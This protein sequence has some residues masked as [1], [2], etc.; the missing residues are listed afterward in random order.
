VLFR[1]FKKKDKEAFKD[2][3]F[4]DDV[5]EGEPDVNNPETEQ[6]NKNEPDNPNQGLLF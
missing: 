3:E 5:I 2:I 1:S 6:P 4:E